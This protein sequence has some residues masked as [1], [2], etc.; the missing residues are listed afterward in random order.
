MK[1]KEFKKEVQELGFRIIEDIGSISIYYGVLRVSCVYKNELLS[2]STAYAAFDN[3]SKELKEKLYNLI[4]K[5]VKT[6]IEDRKEQRKYYLKHKWL[7]RSKDIGYYLNLYLDE[8]YFLGNFAEKGS[9][10]T[11]F[12]QAEIDKIKE[13]FNTSLEDFEQIPVEDEV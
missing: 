2:V 7:R 12:T 10:K 5:Y 3:L 6:P 11:Q 13:R 9:Y 1:T 4:D 8:D